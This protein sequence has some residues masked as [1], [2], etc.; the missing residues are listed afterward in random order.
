MLYT[1]IG[2][3]TGEGNG[4]LATRKKIEGGGITIWRIMNGKI[5][6][7]WSEFDQLRI[8]KDLWVASGIGRVER[9]T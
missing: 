7:E 5:T 1:G 3:N 4:L 2:T 9:R 8:M 6:E